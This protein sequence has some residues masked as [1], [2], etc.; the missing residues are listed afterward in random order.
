MSWC[1][2]CCFQRLHM[3]QQQLCCILRL[4]H[5]HASHSEACLKA[6]H[7]QKQYPPPLTLVGYLRISMAPKVL[8]HVHLP[9]HFCHCNIF[10]ILVVGHRMFICQKIML[11]QALEMCTQFTPFK[12]DIY[13]RCTI[14][15]SAR[16]MCKISIGKLPYAQMHN[17]TVQYWSKHASLP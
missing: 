11:S 16:K 6:R 3:V 12:D 2:F 10:D 13:S 15:K 1:V 4:W 14:K 17:C 7:R 9:Q 5:M 8:K